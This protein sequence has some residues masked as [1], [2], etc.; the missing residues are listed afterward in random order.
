MTWCKVRAFYGNKG[1][2]ISI[3][4]F[5]RFTIK[6]DLDWD[7]GNILRQINGEFTF[8]AFA[9]ASY[10]LG[11]QQTIRV[12]HFKDDIGVP[13]FFYKLNL[14]GCTGIGSAGHFT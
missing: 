7:Q 8:G 5:L 2:D 4:P 3:F 13:G 1:K 6:G 14:R 10:L 12:K 11:M 9:M